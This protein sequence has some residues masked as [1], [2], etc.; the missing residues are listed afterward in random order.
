MNI[1]IVTVH[2]SLNYGSYFQAYAL[3]KVISESGHST[4]F[5]DT[6]ARKP[7]KQTVFSVVKRL[8]KNKSSDA[9]FLI[10]KY[11]HFRRAANAFQIC[12]NDDISIKKQDVFVFGSDEIWNISRKEFEDFPIF[13]GIGMPKDSYLVSYAPSINTTTLDALKNKSHF[14]EAINRFNNISVRDRHSKNVLSKLTSKSINIVLD[15]TFL[16][17]KS[18]YRT[19]E[20]DCNESKYILVYSY[21][22]KMTQKRIEQIKNFAKLKNLKLISVGNILDW[23]DYS[24]P[25]SPFEFLSYINKA[26]FIL[27]DTFH[28]TVFSIIYNKAFVSFCDDN[29]KISE[30]LSQFNL[31]SRNCNSDS[32]LEAVLDERIEYNEV[33]ILIQKYVEDSMR[34]LSLSIDKGET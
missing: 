31:Q 16:L 29:T 18:F 27:T 3:N 32:V 14:V 17:E 4:C 10:T 7:F 11:N 34:Y 5:L 6:K 1:C 25:A 30:V 28:G 26:D 12:N 13:F 33:N 21:G 23:C 9:K 24:I 19:L 15:P 20:V 2:N 8:L 22:H